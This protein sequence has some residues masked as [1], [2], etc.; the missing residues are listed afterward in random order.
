[1]GC[2]WPAIAG[3]SGFLGSLV[4]GLALTV[5]V[6]RSIPPEVPNPTE[7]Y[8]GFGDAMMRMIWL[9]LGSG[10]SFLLA[11]MIGLAVATSMSGT[12]HPIAPPGRGGE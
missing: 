3:L 10:A 6:V 2:F 11:L 9:H 7:A 12:T 4:H 5:L 8:E 1:V